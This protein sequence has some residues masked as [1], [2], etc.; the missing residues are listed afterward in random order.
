MYSPQSASLLHL[1]YGRRLN[2]E[3]AAMDSFYAMHEIYRFVAFSEVQWLNMLQAVL[4][5]ELAQSRL[6]RYSNPTLS[7]LLYQR[8]I[9][10][11]H[12]QRLRH[13]IDTIRDRSPDSWPSDVSTAS[14]KAIANA[15]AESLI[16]DFQN[17]FDRC[18][19]LLQQCSQG[20]QIVAHN[21]TIKESREA[22]RQA[23]EVA[24][25]TQLAFFF[26]PLTFVTS[27][28]GMNCKGL[29]KLELW[30]WVVVSIP[31]FVVS[32][33]L[34]KYDLQV[35]WDRFCEWIKKKWQR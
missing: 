5:E 20:T 18:Q 34:L 1:D 16:R 33:I 17:L 26:I 31:V 13:T 11:R 3:V 9:L 28:F 19:N 4:K 27:I 2:V 25:L 15:A 24:K 8:E 32:L 14:G 7:N 12:S 29:D 22:I 30:V 10:E 35:T 23:E 21:A 6:A